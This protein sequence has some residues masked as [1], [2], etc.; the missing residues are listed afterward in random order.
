M[1]SEMSYSS[2]CSVDVLLFICL[3]HVVFIFIKE[4]VSEMERISY[5]F[6][7]VQN[8]LACKTFCLFFRPKALVLFFIK[9][10]N[11]YMYVYVEIK[12]S[13]KRKKDLWD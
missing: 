13:S 9:V 10:I 5:K 8:Y 12:N 11:A 4:F 3:L 7:V 6:Q 1:R 2:H